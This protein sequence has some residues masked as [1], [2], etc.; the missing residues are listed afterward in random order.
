[1]YAPL[2]PK[3]FTFLLSNPYEPSDPNVVYLSGDQFRLSRNEDRFV[4]GYVTRVGVQP[5]RV[6][7]FSNLEHKQFRE[8]ESSKVLLRVYNK[9]LRFLKYIWFNQNVFDARGQK[10][11]TAKTV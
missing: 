8:M 4:F 11:F 1:M 2:H 10:K 6:H 3:T 7:I 9:S 5:R